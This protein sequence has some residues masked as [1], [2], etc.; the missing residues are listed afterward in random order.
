MNPHFIFNALN[1]IQECVITNKTEEAYL[2]LSK[3]SKLVRLILENSRE[4]F[5]SVARETEALQLYLDL[6]SLRFDD[7]QSNIE[8]DR[9]IEPEADFIPAMIIQPYAENAIKHGLRNKKEDRKLKITLTKNQ[10]M[11]HCMIEDN[12]VGRKQAALLQKETNHISR[13]IEITETRMKLITNQ[14]QASSHISIADLTDERGLPCGTRVEIDLPIVNAADY[15][16]Y[17]RTEFNRAGNI[18]GKGE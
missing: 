17:L 6:E 5:V 2:Y 15:N 16:N 14:L 10:N 11:I 18:F 13:G 12:G 9:L 1:S 3:F 7:L 4:N 8:V